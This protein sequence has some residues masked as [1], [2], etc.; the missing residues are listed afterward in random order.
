LPVSGEMKEVPGE[1]AVSENQ[2]CHD[3]GNGRSQCND[4]VKRRD[5]TLE[6]G[7]VRFFGRRLACPDGIETVDH[8][9]ACSKRQE[10]LTPS[11]SFNS[12]AESSVF[13]AYSFQA[14]SR[15][16]LRHLSTVFSSR[17]TIVAPFA[18]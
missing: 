10:T 11:A 1:N 14:V 3:Q 17:S 5:K 12:W 13:C 2:R 16:M 9:A 4:V 18:L 15:A 8:R 6:A 7:G